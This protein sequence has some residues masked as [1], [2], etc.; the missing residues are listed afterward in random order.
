MDLDEIDGVVIMTDT[1]NTDQ[2][3][4]AYYKDIYFSN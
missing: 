3:A 1:D 4:V 2:K